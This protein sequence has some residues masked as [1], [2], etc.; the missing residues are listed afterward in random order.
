MKGREEGKERNDLRLKNILLKWLNVTL[1][2][3]LIHRP[4]VS[5]FVTDGQR[6]PIHSTYTYNI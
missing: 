6:W 3:K 2:E 4:S 5:P 1:W